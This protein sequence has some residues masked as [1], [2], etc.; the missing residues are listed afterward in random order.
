MAGTNLIVPDDDAPRG[1]GHR[2]D[3]RSLVRIRLRAYVLVAIALSGWVGSVLLGA[4]LLL[5]RSGG[6]SV[7]AGPT[8][9]AAPRVLVGPVVVADPWTPTPF[10]IQVGPNAPRDG[11]VRITGIP[12]LASLTE[13]H[14]IGRGV[15]K[16]QLNGLSSLAI[17]APA[18]DTLQSELLIA[19]MSSEGTVMGEVKSVLAVIAPAMCGAVP[20]IR[21][22]SLPDDMTPGPAKTP[23]SLQK[24]P[25]IV[26]GG[27]RK[28]A[29]ELLLLGE[30]QRMEGR[31]ASARGYYEQ[32]AHMGSPLGAM[33]LAATFDPHEIVGTTLRPD[34]EAARAWY[35]HSRELMD[36]SVSY[37]LKRLKQ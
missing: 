5:G 36:A 21:T 8:V 32:A 24:L 28:R 19:L 25:V 27:D 16:V 1:G 31:L 2:D 7:T 22:R 30:M 10:P 29:Q 34:L 14:T 35:E 20:S 9:T 15:W 17:M 12:A 18:R 23:P 6:S 4:A 37:Y 26:S 11:W 3:R 13:G 33:A